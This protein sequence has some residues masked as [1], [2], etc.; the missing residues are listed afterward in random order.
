MAFDNQ[1]PSVLVRGLLAL[2]NAGP[3]VIQEVSGFFAI[4]ATQAEVAQEDSDPIAAED[5]RLVSVRRLQTGLR[6][7]NQML[8]DNY[9]AIQDRIPSGDT[10][11]GRRKQV[12]RELT[13]IRLVTGTGDSGF[14]P[15]VSYD[16]FLA[17]QKAQGHSNAGQLVQAG[18]LRS[19]RHYIETLPLVDV[20]KLL[21]RAGMDAPKV[22]V[23]DILA[24]TPTVLSVRQ[25]ERALEQMLPLSG[26]TKESPPPRAERTDSTVPW[27]GRIAALTERL[28][29]GGELSDAEAATIMLTFAEQNNKNRPSPQ[30]TLLAF[31]HVTGMLDPV[32]QAL[33]QHRIGQPSARRRGLSYKEIRDEGLLGNEDVTAAEERLVRRLADIRDGT[34]RTVQ[35]DD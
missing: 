24:A 14:P 16:T 13:A 10:Q 32:T 1:P 9:Q 12:T 18:L 22:S 25:M 23:A 31:A 21:A 19:F 27:R 20:S 11:A 30:L 2:A 3:Q 34:V 15:A 5:A 17:E 35:L 33:L 28:Q 4:K 7:L 29:A 6:I 8:S 26:D